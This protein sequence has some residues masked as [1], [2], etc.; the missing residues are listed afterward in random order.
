MLC[1]NPR[2]SL[3]P[4]QRPESDG[5][6]ES[7]EKRPLLQGTTPR[8]RVAREHFVANDNRQDTDRRSPAGP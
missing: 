5:R 1:G 4:L 2:A 3:F 7:A 6:L 8:S